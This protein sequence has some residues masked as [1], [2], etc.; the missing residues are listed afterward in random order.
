MALRHVEG[1]WFFHG[2]SPDPRNVQVRGNLLIFRMETAVSTE[3]GI[4]VD[5]GTISGQNLRVPF[6]TL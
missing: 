3:L 2:S 6:P 1:S 4:D 5:Y